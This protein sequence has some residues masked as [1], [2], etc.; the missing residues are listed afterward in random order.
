MKRISFIKHGIYRYIILAFLLL[1][2]SLLIILFMNH[3]VYNY[4]KK[5]SVE[6][7]QK[8]A[9]TQ[10]LLT[11]K[12]AITD[13]MR[14]DTL[15]YKIGDN[16]DFKSEEVKKVLMDIS[17]SG[18]RTMEILLPDDTVISGK[19]R[20]LPLD[21]TFDEVNQIGNH[22]SGRLVSASTSENIITHFIPMIYDDEITGYCCISL[23]CDYITNH[24]S[25]T[26]QFIECCIVDTR[27]MDII[28][29]SNGNY[30][31]NLKDFN[32]TSI[33]GQ[34][35]VTIDETLFSN[36]FRVF[37]AKLSN[38]PDTVYFSFL[39]SAMDKYFIVIYITES[40][41]FATLHEYR[42]MTKTALY[43]ELILVL[44]FFIIL[45][46]DAHYNLR[47]AVSKEKSR[48]QNIIEILAS[49]Y[50]ALY[51]YN[52]ETDEAEVIYLNEELKKDTG[53]SIQ[54][55]SNLHDV[56]INFVNT[57]VHPDDR[58]T[59]IDAI[60]LDTLKRRL[61]NEK[62]YTEIF[63]RNYDGQYLYTRLSVVKAENEKD[64][65]VHVAIGFAEVDSEFKKE[66]ARQIEMSQ[67]LE[68]AYQDGLTGL[69][70]KYAYRQAEE[71]LDIKLTGAN[72]SPFAI[73]V[74]DVNNLKKVNDT[75]GHEAGDKLI[76]DAAKLVC[77][78]FKH[79]PVYR[80]GGDEFAV[81]ITGADY[82]AR[83][84]IML[85]FRD[86]MKQNA[87]NNDAVVI[88]SGI[89][90]FIDTDIS[91]SVVFN[92]ADEDMYLNKASLKK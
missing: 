76:C 57:L 35:N 14:F 67:T 62:S 59:V 78:T 85:Q 41:M 10:T 26:E 37:S 49:G 74:F 72:V 48:R 38:Y 52:I 8:V 83:E 45:S 68:I 86:Q 20:T 43:M 17:S 29:N 70:N 6:K 87:Q 7:I 66:Q 16:P 1:G 33:D 51:Y 71:I 39:P 58:K 88:A 47:K 34:K 12:F 53:K 18:Q 81:I 64:K 90:S 80:V 50:T 11:S 44:L 65:P 56:Y 13:K 69:K 91:C 92:R 63:R 40:Q 42:K 23:T 61:E 55:L 21:I 27:T 3:K 4:A 30:E 24:I 54:A 89:A 73:A 75:L 32:F 31:H 25:T 9:E 60:D 36:H 84:M 79:S 15:C 2:F 46:F 5:E 28:A 22:F 77:N 82:E 19:A